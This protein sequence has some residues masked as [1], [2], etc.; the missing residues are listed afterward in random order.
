MQRLFAEWGFS[1]AGD[2]DLA[3]DHAGVVL[4][5]LEHLVAAERARWEIDLFCARAILAIEADFLRDHVWNWFPGW[6]ERLYV[7][8]ELP[9]YRSLA[10]VLGR[11]LETEKTTLEVLSNECPTEAKQT[12]RPAGL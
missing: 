9:F 11:F 2:G 1:P 10:L 4:S 12:W 8:A 3:P 5:F 6:L 7:R